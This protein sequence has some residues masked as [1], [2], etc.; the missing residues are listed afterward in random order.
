[1]IQRRTT[2]PGEFSPLTTWIG[3][4]IL[5]SALTSAVVPP[6]LANAT[7][8]S[9]STISWPTS[10]MADGIIS[11]GAPR[12]YLTG[13]EGWG[14]APF[15]SLG[16][17]GMEWSSQWD[18]AH[19]EPF[20]GTVQASSIN[21]GGVS[22]W[23]TAGLI[24]P[25]PDYNFVSRIAHRLEHNQMAWTIDMTVLDEDALVPNRFFWI[26]DLGTR[27]SSSRTVMS[28]VHAI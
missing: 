10:Q 26:A 21:P 9:T 17:S 15:S 13:T 11:G 20:Y 14:L 19:R 25:L 24:S 23:S 22:T 1:M 6:A 27:A 3:I 12:D 4:V 2:A 28:M 8:F 5:G 18:P 7:A 16:A